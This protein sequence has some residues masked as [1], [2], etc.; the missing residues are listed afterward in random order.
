MELIQ[1]MG[2]RSNSKE[3]SSQNRSLLV[4]LVP[5]Q[6][7]RVPLPPALGLAGS[8]FLFLFSCPSSFLPLSP[9]GNARVS[10]TNRARG[11]LQADLSTR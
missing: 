6:T 3:D 1:S 9:S 8:C 10:S 4:S 7:F 5:V 2:G 11:Q